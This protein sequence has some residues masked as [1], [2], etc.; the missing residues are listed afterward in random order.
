MLGAMKRSGFL[1]LAAF[2]LTSATFG[3]LHAETV[4]HDFSKWEKEI[5]AFEKADA[6]NPPPKGVVIFTGASSIRMWTT[7]AADFPKTKLINRGFGGCEIE[8]VTHFAERILIPHQPRAIY[9]RAGGND[10]WHGKTPE[11]V[12][13]DFKQ[14]VSTVH[15]KLPD[16]DIIFISQS[17]SNSRWKQVEKEKALNQLI[18]D[19]IKGK[20]HLRYIDTFDMPLGADGR[21][22]PELYIADQLHFNAGGYKLLAERVRPDLEK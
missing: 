5:A 21:P 18:A 16:T 3:T 19:H 12:F 9:L 10:L 17:P 6:S 4:P 14:F 11:Q 1:K 8:D 13:E 20:P 22:R 7:L 15:A 2:I